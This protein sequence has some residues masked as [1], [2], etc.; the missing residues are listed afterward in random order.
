MSVLDNILLCVGCTIQ[1]LIGFVVLST[2]YDTQQIGKQTPEGISAGRF[3]FWYLIFIPFVS[4]LVVVLMKA[5]AD[6]SRMRVS[7]Q[8][9]VFTGLFGILLIALLVCAYWLFSTWTGIALTTA[10][11]LTVYVISQYLVMRRNKFVI[12]K[13][14]KYGNLVVFLIL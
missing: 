5:R 6:L 14:F 11:F 4:S 8:L 9:G 7:W 1:F 12:H 2:Q 13:Y 10:L 3:M